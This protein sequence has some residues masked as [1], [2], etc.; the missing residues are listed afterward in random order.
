MVGINAITSG[1]FAFSLRGN[2][3]CSKLVGGRVVEK[4]IGMV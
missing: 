1:F 3:A 4:A 2:D